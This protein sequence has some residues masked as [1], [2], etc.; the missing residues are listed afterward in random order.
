[1]TIVI[2][3]IRTRATHAGLPAGDEIALVPLAHPQPCFA[4][5]MSDSI[6]QRALSIHAT[7]AEAIEQAKR[8]QE[9][10]ACGVGEQV[11]PGRRVQ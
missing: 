8:V 3:V 6:G 5:A 7:E 4:V 10:I 9:E 2:S 11:V 1:M